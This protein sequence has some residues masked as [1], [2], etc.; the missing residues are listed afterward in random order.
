ME[1]FGVETVYSDSGVDLTQLRGNLCHTPDQ[2]MR[3]AARNAKNLFSLTRLQTHHKPKP[4]ADFEPEALLRQLHG[5]V[6][7]VLV[8]GLAMIAHGSA[9]VTKALDVCYDR[10]E[11]NLQALAE[12]LAPLHPY[13]RGVPAGLPFKL[14]VPTLHSGL[15]FTLTTDQGDLDLLGEL[16]GLGVYDQVAAAAQ[17]QTIFAMPML[18]LTLDGLITAKK[19]AGRTKDQLHLLELLELKKL[20]QEPRD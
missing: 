3:S 1:F 14:D 10:T 16:S 17:E 9:Y 6:R 15:N 12:A 20:L 7:F 8:G 18:V 4:M 5:K 2:R 13:L 11:A 19:A